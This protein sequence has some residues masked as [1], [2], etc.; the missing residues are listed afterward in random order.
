MT[1][2]NGT[3]GGN[4]SGGGLKE[5]SVKGAKASN[6]FRQNIRRAKNKAKTTREKRTHTRKRRPR[7]KIQLTMKSTTKPKPKRKRRKITSVGTSSSVN[8]SSS[9]GTSRVTS[10][11]KKNSILRRKQAKTQKRP[12]RVRW[13][14][15]VTGA[16]LVSCE[17][18]T[19]NDYTIRDSPLFRNQKPLRMKYTQ[20]RRKKTPPVASQ[21]T[22]TNIVVR[23]KIH[24]DTKGVDVLDDVEVIHEMNAEEASKR[25]KE[26][27]IDTNRKA[28]LDLIKNL[29]ILSHGFGTGSIQTRG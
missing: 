24:D 7:T 3:G 1:T 25:L 27:G 21:N 19:H 18:G 6:S 23:W 26:V 29:A 8:K 4:D 2:S 9:V 20:K 12:R 11:T 5:V 16:S 28:P 14:D 22:P 10:Q 17:Q 15:Q 13:K